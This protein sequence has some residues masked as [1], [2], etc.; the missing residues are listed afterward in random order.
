[1]KGGPGTWF[2]SAI[3]VFPISLAC[4]LSGSDVKM[5]LD[6]VGVGLSWWTSMTNM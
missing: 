6:K 3:F 4:V 5:D 1:M 2:L